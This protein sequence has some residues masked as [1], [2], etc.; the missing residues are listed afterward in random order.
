MDLPDVN[1]SFFHSGIIQL[2][3]N[4]LK[5]TGGILSNVE[6]SEMEICN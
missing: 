2:C 6:V 3:W 4:V 1:I 5:Y